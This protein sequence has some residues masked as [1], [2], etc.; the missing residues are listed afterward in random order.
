ME[1]SAGDDTYVFGLG[2]GQDVIYDSNQGQGTN[3]DKVIFLE[4]TR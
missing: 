4:G 1:G 2:Y 3:L